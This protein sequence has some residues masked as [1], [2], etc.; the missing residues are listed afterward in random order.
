MD[1]RIKVLSAFMIGALGLLLLNLLIVGLLSGSFSFAVTQFLK[2]KFFLIPI[3]IGFG[4]QA[5]LVQ[6][7]KARAVN[8][9]RAIVGGSGAYNTTS[10]AAC[11]AHHVTDTL[12]FLAAG[13]VASFFST[14]QNYFLIAAIIIN[15]TGV[16]YLF[17]KLKRI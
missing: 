9:S 1:A 5:A 13:G 2:L 16:V 4:V 8:R 14:Y 3:I 15:W 11:C 12:P 7:L 6:L 17:N 10:M